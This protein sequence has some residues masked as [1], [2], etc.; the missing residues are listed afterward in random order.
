MNKKDMQAM[1]QDYE[2]FCTS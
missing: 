2:L 1:P